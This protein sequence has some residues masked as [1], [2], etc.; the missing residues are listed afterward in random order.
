MSQGP[1]KVIL[2]YSEK[3]NS[4]LEEFEKH[5][6]VLN[7]VSSDN[8][9]YACGST[10]SKPLVGF[11]AYDIANISLDVLHPNTTITQSIVFMPIKPPVSLLEHVNEMYK[12][13]NAFLFASAQF[14][15]DEKTL[16]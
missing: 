1:N 8:D 6:N 11:L 13:A 7:I 9:F 15:L 14:P 3:V 16:L 5:R 4:L 10:F 12:S 2:Y